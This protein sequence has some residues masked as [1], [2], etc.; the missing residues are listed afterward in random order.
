MFSKSTFFFALCSSF[1]LSCGG[2]GGVTTGVD[3]PL[4]SVDSTETWTVEGLSAPVTVVWTEGAIPHVY[5]HNRQ[6]LRRVQ[7]FLVAR[8]RFFQMDLVRRL[9][10][11]RLSELMGDIMLETDLESR[12]IAMTWGTE[13]LLAALTEE[14]RVEY[15]AYADGFNDYIDAVKRGELPQPSEYVMAAP[16][17]GVT[18]PTDLL[19]PWE[20]RDVA[21]IGGSI[22][23]RLGYETGDVG[24]ADQYLTLQ[25]LPVDVDLADIRQDYA[26][27][28][29]E[30][31]RPVFDRPSAAGLGTQGTGGAPASSRSAG[32]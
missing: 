26:Y 17:L 22:L 27:E 21:A 25:T 23:Y 24:R 9:S 2:N 18:E 10:T 3:S 16:L 32:I 12:G 15:T 28:L 30:D 14:Q 11:G 13:Q 6:D 5:A 4:N 1:L 19:V 7:G 29:W 8:D 31:V 20:L